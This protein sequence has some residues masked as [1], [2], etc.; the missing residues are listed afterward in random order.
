MP[1]PIEGTF[2]VYFATY[3]N[4]VPEDDVLQALHNQQQLID[5]FCNAIP[6]EKWDFAYAPGKWTLKEMMQHIIDTERIFA[7]RSLCISRRETQ[8]LPGFDENTYVA[9]SN[10]ATRSWESLT[11]ELKAVRSST[12][13]LFESFNQ[14]MLNSSGISNNNAITV[15]ALGFITVGHIYHHIGVINERYLS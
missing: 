14:D 10:A 3:T 12:V 6:P 7:Y 1:K 8:S 9:N 2:P 5:G 13:F 15:N 11:D 4:K